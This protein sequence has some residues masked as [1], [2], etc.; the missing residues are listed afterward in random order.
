MA[1]S[2]SFDELSAIT[3]MSRLVLFGTI[4]NSVQLISTFDIGNLVPALRF[5]HIQRIRK[6]S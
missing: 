6:Q 2:K 4:C 3:K 1:L 5:L